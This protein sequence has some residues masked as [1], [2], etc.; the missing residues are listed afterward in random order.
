MTTARRRPRSS[1]WCLHRAAVT[2]LSLLLLAACVRQGQ[3][4][5]TGRPIDAGGRPQE[6]VVCQSIA[7]DEHARTEVV[8]TTLLG[9]A[10]LPAP[11]Q[12]GQES[13]VRGH[14]TERDVVVFARQT[15]SGSPE[16]KELFVESLDR[17]VAAVRLTRDGAID[18]EPCW[19]PD[20]TG[21][22][23]ASD[24]GGS[25][26]LWRI[27]RDGSRLAPL[28]QPPPGAGDRAPDVRGGRV[29]FART[30]P[31][32]T[33]R[34][35][36]WTMNTDGSGAA[37][38]TDGGTGGTGTGEF[39][40]GDHEPALAPGGESIVFVRRTAPER[41][42]LMLL[43]LATNRLSEIAPTPDGEDR[44]P[45]FLPGA[46]AIVAARSSESQGIAGRR[47]VAM[48]LDG[49]DLAW[50]AL[51]GRIA[52]QGADLLAG[53]APLPAPAA[54]GVR[55]ALEE[56]DAQIVLG[57]RTLGRFDLVRE[58]DGSGLQLATVTSADK[59]RAGA[60]LPFEL[61]LA[62]PSGVARV[63]VAATFSLTVASAEARVRLSVRN[64]EAGRYDV[65]WDGTVPNTRPV[66]VVFT[67]AS[68]AHIDRDGWIRIE[69]AAELPEGERAELAIDAVLVEAF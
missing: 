25:F 32:P 10:P 9:L 50:L 57:R 28:T 41:A 20:G 2:F 38:L 53:A 8:A 19:W 34:S 67:F 39:V 3:G 4:R 68:L 16:S 43:E 60:F 49:S 45:R 54:S 64:Y 11:A 30:T 36:I 69:L 6:L 58:K 13:G 35:A 55:A 63:R 65:A 23:F 46:T 40:P 59:E 7:G 22:V 24:R 48:R 56:D 12:P 15:R 37:P 52:V 62:D 27:D 18:C 47:L 17:F 33:L 14:P 44:F 31:A 29:V 42:T 61:P 1:A 5:R 26:A 66:D 21:V 51:D